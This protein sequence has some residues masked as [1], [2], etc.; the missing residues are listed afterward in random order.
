M[1]LDSFSDW[2][3]AVWST[4]G[5]VLRLDSA[6]FNAVLDSPQ[7]LG[8]AILILIL[9]ALSLG[10][11]QSVVLFA[12]RVSPRGFI[13]SL[14]GGALVLAVGSFLWALS[15]WGVALLYPGDHE[16]LRDFYVLVCLGSA[17]LVFGLF[18][19][20]PYLGTLIERVLRVY[21]L[22]VV[23]VGL[24]A[25]LDFT[26][27]QSLFSA[28]LGWLIYM[29]ITHMPLFDLDQAPIWLWQRLTGKR[30]R[31]A[32]DTLAL[33]LADDVHNWVAGGSELTMPASATMPDSGGEVP[34]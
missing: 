29:S 9:G 13:L 27:L 8:V 7:G 16:S 17:P 20:L 26:W 21:A 33:A 12:N 10:M 34:T 28:G 18:V 4:L 23:L 30:E 14:M 2:W 32:T 24:H 6:T 1:T 11:G 25:G 31:F 19:L 5:G 3:N 15:A 22:L